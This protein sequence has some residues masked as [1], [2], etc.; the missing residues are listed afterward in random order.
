M[1]RDDGKEY[2]QERGKQNDQENEHNEHSIKE[3]KQS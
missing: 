1:V 3:A 2:V